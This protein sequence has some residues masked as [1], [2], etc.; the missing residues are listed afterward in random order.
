MTADHT[1]N[2]LLQC[3]ERDHRVFDQLELIPF[4]S[5][6][7]LYPQG[8]A[9]KHVFFPISGIV[10]LVYMMENGDSVELAIVGKE[11][12]VGMP[13]VIAGGKTQHRALTQVSGQGY[14]LSEKSFQEL[15]NG[16]D[17][18]R[19]VFLYYNLPITSQTSMNAVCNRYHPIEQQL[20]KWLLLCFDRLEG[21]ELRMTQESIGAM[22]GVRREGIN[23]AAARL[24][25]MGAISYRRGSITLLDRSKLQGLVC[26]CYQVVQDEYFR[27]SQLRIC[28]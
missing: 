15:F 10:S 2:T 14:R 18:F 8:V 27:L 16:C 6:R 22:I 3:F 1:G 17:L 24:Q 19:K 20:C 28:G 23:A 7:E 26:S 5:Q 4:E 21:N 11:G 13:M 12:A 9:L 25:A